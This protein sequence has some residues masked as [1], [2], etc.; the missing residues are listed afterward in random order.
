[1][2]LQHYR[3]MFCGIT[4]KNYVAQNVS[5]TSLTTVKCGLKVLSNGSE[6]VIFVFLGISTVNDYHE[7]NTAFILLTILFCTVYRALG[8]GF[9]DPLNFFLNTLFWSDFYLVAANVGVVLLTEIANYF[10]LHQL[11]RVEKF[12]MSY[13][14]LRGAI[15]FALVLLIDP[16]RI[17]RQPLFAT[18]TISVVFFT[19]F[20]QV[21]TSIEHLIGF[22]SFD[23]RNLI[24]QGITI[25]PLVEFLKV[26]RE[27]K[28]EKTMNERLHEKVWHPIFIFW[29][30]NSRLLIANP[31]IRVWQVL[32]YTMVGM[33][34]ILGQLSSNKIRDK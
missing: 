14:G 8:K 33:V 21:L 13:G 30:F 31:I 32:D 18:A 1:M 16:N 34:D 9:I 7:W 25:K 5:P 11:N 22:F 15:A 24:E 26:K 6:S 19:V 28:R 23:Y 17:P 20:I 3:I 2:K 29:N 12:I 10:R 4:M 27:E